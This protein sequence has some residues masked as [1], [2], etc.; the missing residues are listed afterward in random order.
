MENNIKKHNKNLYKRLLK[1]ARPYLWY[2]IASITIILIIVAIELYQ[3]VLLGNAVDTFLSQYG[4]SEGSVILDRKHDIEGIIKIGGLYLL[5][6]VIMFFL[7]YAQ[8]LILSFAGQKIIYNIRMEIFSHLSNLP[9]SFFTKTPIGK[10]VT[11]VTNDTEALNEMY[12][13]VIVN[14]LK[15]CFVLIGIILT[16]ISYNLK[17]SIYTFT[18]IPFIMIFTFVFQHV[19]MKIH[20]DIRSKIS[21]MNAFISEHVSGMKIVQ[22][23]AVE[24]EVFDKFK[25]ENEK[26]R[27]DHMKQLFTFSIYNPTNFLM[28]IAATSILL[29]VGGNLVLDGIIS[30]GTIVVFQRYISKFF[31]PI[32][33]LAEQLNIIQSA[34]AA[35]E[36]IFDLLDEEQEIKGIENPV[37]M[38]TF[39]GSIE[40]KNVWFAYV[41]NEWILKD[42]SFKVNPGESIAFVGATGAGKTTIQSL[43]CRYYD[44]QKGEILI[45]GV[46]IRDI[47]VSDLRKNIGQMLQDVF[48]FSGDIKSN[49]RLKN[50]DITDEDIIEASKYVNADKFISKLENKYDY[51]VIENG[52]AFSAG[53]RQL[54]SFAR[55]LAFKPD[56]LILDEATANIDT[57]TEVLI[58]DALRKIMKD[59]TTLIVA[60]RLSTIQNS[61]KIIVMHKGEIREEG[62][63]QKL[64]T[65]K[66]IY[67]KL[68][69]LQ[70]EER[71]HTLS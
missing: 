39:K 30:I 11:R 71:G 9:L 46:N 15:S 38:D 60:H 62:T 2:F 48:L 52:A 54:I 69:K 37:E 4:S 47:Q 19:S 7:N 32:Q 10:L 51:H 44:I 8:A 22:I 65:E 56:V 41:E 66:G 5:T 28:N 6:V 55:T 12:T 42:V 26:L 57:E 53:Q 34:S 50:K 35:S 16:M 40:F 67:Y 1:Y 14:V 36:R 49:V 64:L 17:L 21:G 58:Q 59:R 70:Y 31:E 13:S 3:P 33:E 43:I 63:H 27:T 45:D 20:R 23:F 24:N 61:D 29:W 68:Y 18:V 25:N